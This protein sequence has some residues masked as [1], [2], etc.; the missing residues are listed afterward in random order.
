MKSKNSLGTL[1]PA[2]LALGVFMG[3]VGCAHANNQS[4][5]RP[6]PRGG[7]G[8]SLT[9]DDIAG[10][11]GVSIEQLLASRVAGVT[12]AQARDG[13]LVIRIRGQNS[14]LG[15]QDPLFV[16]N[17]I[18]LGRAA[19]FAAINR[20]DIATID[21]VKDAAGMAMYGIR[22]ANGVIVVRTK[23]ART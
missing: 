21:V 12:L 10:A 11:P 5:V 7:R 22:G 6:T 4:T 20:Y 15:D 23:G 9:A 18:P 2:A 14:L 17:G 1:L 8:A 3:C 13:H 16:V 19:N